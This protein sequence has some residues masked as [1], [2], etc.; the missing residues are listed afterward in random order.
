MNYE[1]RLETSSRKKI[2]WTEKYRPKQ[3]DEIISH[4]QIKL[5]L[6]NFIKTNSLPNL[7]FSGPSGSGKTS[8]IK[9]CAYEMYG[10]YYKCM[11]LELNASSERGIDVVR[12]KIKEFSSSNNTVFLPEQ[13]KTLV[14]L[15]ILDETESMTVEAQGLLRHIIEQYNRD[16]RY[17]I[18]CND[19][20]KINIALQSRCA[21][22]RFYPLNPDEMKKRLKQICVE[23]K[24]TYCK[25]SFDAIV[26]ISKG[27]MR[28]AI[29]ILQHVSL[30]KNRNITEKDIYTISGHCMPGINKKIFN[31]LID[32]SEEKKTLFDTNNDIYN[33]VLDNN[34]TIFN[35]LDY[36][37]NLVIESKFDNNQKMYIIENMAKC[38]IYD[39]ANI[40]TQNTIM[41]LSS[42]FLLASRC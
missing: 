6:T 25:K 28:A 37:K 12:S 4:S 13:I 38:Q 17:C 5:S 1:N 23:E 24:V 19:T 29:N 11:V 22:Y 39:S 18:I 34:I 8:T 2:P 16:T 27:D 42:I 32:L 15:V 10:D 35:L 21:H 31:I 40:D 3:I 20:D 7:L 33:I 9:S 14:K 36:L 26:N 30:T 41:I